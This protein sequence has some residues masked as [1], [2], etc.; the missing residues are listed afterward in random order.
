ML[1][2]NLSSDEI[3]Q[4]V[5]ISA[6][7]HDV[8]HS[9]LEAT[10]SEETA[11]YIVVSTGSQ[12]NNLDML[13]IQAV[14]SLILPAEE[15]VVQQSDIEVSVVNEENEQIVDTN[16]DCNGDHHDNNIVNNNIIDNDENIDQSNDINT[17]DLQTVTL[18]QQDIPTENNEIHAIA[19]APQEENTVCVSTS[20][21]IHQAVITVDMVDSCS[22]EQSLD[23]ST[24]M[25]ATCSHEQSLDI[26]ADMMDPCN[27]EQSLDISS[28][29]EENTMDVDES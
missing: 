14:E 12:D 3:I 26:A 25:M 15:Q 16:G 4:N 10:G 22:Q 11:S 29:Q 24:D 8:Q 20:D 9:M 7:P 23:I 27:Q 21:T 6:N 19:V 13:D 28:I 1:H 5:E 2:T 18:V 17:E